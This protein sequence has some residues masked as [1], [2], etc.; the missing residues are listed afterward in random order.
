MIDCA[1]CKK[2]NFAVKIMTFGGFLRD[3]YG[4]GYIVVEAKNSGKHHQGISSQAIP[5]IPVPFHRLL[6]EFWK[7]MGF[8]LRFS[9]YHGYEEHQQLLS[10]LPL[11]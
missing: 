5:N 10:V 7:G 3:R 9:P 1:D 4:A 11:V 2:W 8:R 6:E